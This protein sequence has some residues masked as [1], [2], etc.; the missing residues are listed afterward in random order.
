[1]G[2]DKKKPSG[3]GGT[4]KKVLILVVLLIVGAEVASRVMSMAEWSPYY[5]VMRLVKQR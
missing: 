5:Q 2:D 4:A 1:M 3:K